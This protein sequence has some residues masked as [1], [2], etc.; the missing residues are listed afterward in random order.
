LRTPG[1]E[2]ESPLCCV[3]CLHIRRHQCERKK[4]ENWWVRDVI[5]VDGKALESPDSRTAGSREV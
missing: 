3:G 4:K 5:I 1:Q 2:V